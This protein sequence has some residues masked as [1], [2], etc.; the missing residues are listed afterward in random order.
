[1]APAAAADAQ[2]AAPA[3]IAAADAR[4]PEAPN[5]PEEPRGLRLHTEEALDGWTL[6]APLNSKDI[7]LVDMA[8]KVV[9]TW[10]T[11]HAPGGGT[12]LLENGNLLRSANQEGNPRFHGGGI[13]GRIVELDW[14]G[15]VVW[16]YE[17]ASAERTTHHDFEVMPNGNLL[18]IAW[19]YH[20]PGEARAHG[21]DAD[22]THDEGLWPDIV[23]EVERTH[24]TGGEVVWEWRA[25]DHLVQDRDPAKLGF[26]ALAEHPGR[27]DVNA[28]H[29][30]EPKEESDEERRKR[31]EMAEQMRALG[32]VGDDGP[33]PPPGSP[34]RAGGSPPAG[35]PPLGA[36]APAPSDGPPP[37]QDAPRGPRFESDWLH[38]NSIDLHPELDLLLL[39]TPH[40]SE[41]WVIDHSTTKA[42]AATSSGGRWRHGGDLLYRWGNPQNAGLGGEADQRLFR[43]HHPTWVYDAPASELCVLV[44]NNGPGRP[45]KEYSSVE[46]LVLPFDRARGFLREAG[47]PFGPAAPAWSYQEPEGFYSGFISGAQRLP[48][49]HTL[50]CEGAE[51][52]VFEVTREG[53]IVW[54]WRSPLGGEIEPSKQGGRAPPNALFR[55]TRIPRDHPGLE[56]RL[57]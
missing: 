31:E 39:S 49:G 21:R 24:P 44:F 14:A 32:Y 6:V 4:A 27:I 57:E 17:L 40:L 30:Y 52:R 41:I 29:R 34:P 5:A 20:S 55:A 19:E 26:G 36:G 7:H 1:M 51:G 22:V 38:T 2:P 56:G 11:Q 9:H 16:E 10:K 46:E 12:Y 8:G 43:Q 28:D 47:Q 37:P 35:G 33:P 3:E 25:W 54:D 15:E 48:N 42:E 45:E 18:A 53:R 23:V 50:I 13:G